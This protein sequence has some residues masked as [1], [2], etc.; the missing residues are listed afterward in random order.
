[1]SNSIV[2]SQS[3]LSKDFLEKTV[4]EIEEFL[5]STTI[6]AL[7]DEEPEG[8]KEYYEELLA[9]LRRLYVF[10]DEGLDACK[11][12][13]SADT[14]RKAAAEKTLYW[15]YHQ[16]IQEFY[17]PRNDKWFEDS[18]SAYTG[19]NAI[20][21]YGKTPRSIEKLMA[22]LEKDFQEVR[23]ELEYYETDYKTKIMQSK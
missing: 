3:V 13:L 11:V 21:F 18:R 23:E 2:Y 14:F 7:L 4:K 9:G 22:S 8:S 12:I 19:K 20:K 10:C 6:Q 5:N 17:S 1:M 15:I 16:C